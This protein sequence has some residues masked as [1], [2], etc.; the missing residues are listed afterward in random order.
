MKTVEEKARQPKEQAS[1]EYAD[2]KYQITD[3]N[4]SDHGKMIALQIAS[5]DGFIAGANWQAEQSIKQ[6]IE[7]FDAM[8]LSEEEFEPDYEYHRKQFIA[9]LKTPLK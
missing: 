4:E 7:A 5:C 3:E 8:W 6:A 2:N 9:K 1:E